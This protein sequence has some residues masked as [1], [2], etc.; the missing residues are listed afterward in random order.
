MP[1]LNTGLATPSR[2]DFTIDQSLRFEDS[3]G[4]YLSRTPSASTYKIGTYSFWA[5]RGELGTINSIVQAGRD[6]GGNDQA[7]IAFWSDDK[8][9][10]YSYRSS[11]YELN[12]ITDALYRDTSAWYHIVVAWDTTQG[13]PANRCKVYVNGEQITDFSTETYPDADDLMMFENPNASNSGQCLIGAYWGSAVDTSHSLSGYLSEYHFIDGTQLTPTSF[14]ETGDYGEWKPIEVSGLT[15]GTNGF[16]LSFAGGGIIAATGGT[17]TTVGDYKVHSFTADGTF[18]PTSVPTTDSYVEYLVIAGGGGG[19]GGHG[20]GG[21]AGGYRTGV[22]TVTAQAYSITVGDGGTAGDNSAGSGGAG[23]DGDD[24]VFSTIT[25]TGGGGA[26]GRG[27]ANGRNGGSGGGSNEAN[28][29]G[30]GTAGQGND[31]ATGA[32][33]ASYYGGGG[34]GG[35]G[36][37]GAVGT[38]SGGGDGGAGLASSIT[39]SAVTRGGGGGGGQAHG[40]A[41]SSGG[42]GGGGDGAN[43]NVAGDNGSANTG[44][45]A[46]GGYYSN[47]AGGAGGSG[48]VII[49]YKFQ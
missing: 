2:G 49:R 31:G 4:S 37:V 12:L 32:N 22:L 27:N 39:G 28:T 16:Y 6:G 38:G 43:T 26:G 40:G 20:G 13:T 11:A 30:S 47:S 34:G 18:T 21:G 36:A 10:I 35:A 8:L 23:G 46:G 44:G 14:G 9:Q 1:V 45:G 19:G 42:A 41:Q 33:A 24:S 29:I 5:K 25:S 3:S 7:Q 17:I 15:Y 48:I